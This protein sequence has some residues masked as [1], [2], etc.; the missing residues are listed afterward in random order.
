MVSEKLYWNTLKHTEYFAFS[1]N[2][3]FY[4]N[5]IASIST[6]CQIEHVFVVVGIFKFYG[7][8]IIRLP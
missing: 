7:I 5:L 1:L 2:I 6:F 8:C 3:S 4:C